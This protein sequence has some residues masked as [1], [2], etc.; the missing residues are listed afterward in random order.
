MARIVHLDG[1]FD[2][3]SGDFAVENSILQAGGLSV[4]APREN[5]WEEAAIAEVVLVRAAP[6]GATELRRLKKCHTLIRYGIGTDKIDLSAASRLGIA[7]CNVPD[8]CTEEMASHTLALAL[9]LARRIPESQQIAQLADWS[10]SGSHPIRAL[11][12]MRFV[13]IG[14]GRIARQVLSQARALKFQVAAADPFVDRDG[15]SRQSVLPLTLDE[16][17]STADILSLHC[18]L[19]QETDHL[20]NRA[21]IAQMKPS[22]IVINTARGRLIDTDALTEALS[23]N[24]LQ[25]AGLDVTEPEPLSSSHPL[26]GLPHVVIT[27][28]IAWYSE[29]AGQRL[30]TMVAREALRAIRGD[31]LQGRVNPPC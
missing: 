10:L 15:F 19:T 22:A 13:T 27:P 16:A 25:G 28:H 30:R 2:N 7:V 6:V 5:V 3:P 23:A 29:Q 31:Q 12:E 11:A 26:H 4:R 21:R 14:F 9:T 20:L 17:F 24:R 8:F 1:Y 18:P